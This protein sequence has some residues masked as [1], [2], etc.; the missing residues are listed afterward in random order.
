MDLRKRIERLCTELEQATRE[1]HAHQAPHEY[2]IFVETAKEARKWL[3]DVAPDD[4]HARLAAAE[5]MRT[6]I[7]NL[8]EFYFKAAGYDAPYAPYHRG[9]AAA[10]KEVLD[11]YRQRFPKPDAGEKELPH[12][13]G[14][15]AWSDPHTGETLY[16]SDA[17]KAKPKY[18]CEC[19]FSMTISYRHKA[20][21]IVN[22]EHWPQPPAETDAGEATA[23]CE[24]GQIRCPDCHH[25]P[26]GAQ[27]C[28]YGACECHHEC[29]PAEPA[30]DVL[31][32]RAAQ[33]LL[34]AR[35]FTIERSYDALDKLRA[36]WLA[37]LAAAR[38]G[39]KDK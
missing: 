5:Q 34:N 20:D 15:K 22:Q 31:R 37:D 3:A 11:A 24:C 10:L 32:E 23:R 16:A 4:T 7:E 28:G 25:H 21:C 38:L 18:V 26:H 8:H 27:G 1:V 6:Q 19:P 35:H 17:G 36:L 2:C 29:P 39:R 9:V 14:Y 12:L 13:K 30:P 33:A